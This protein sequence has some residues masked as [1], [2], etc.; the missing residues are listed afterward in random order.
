[1]TSPP[2]LRALFP[3][4]T[5]DERP[6]LLHRRRGAR[7]LAASGA[8]GS[9]ACSRRGVCV[10]PLSRPCWAATLLLMIGGLLAACGVAAR[11]RVAGQ[12]AAPPQE[13]TNT[14]SRG[15]RYYG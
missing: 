15:V 5:A 14:Q 6:R 7:L 12:D 9:L 10:G 4:I 3:V 1:M 8:A 11:R 2:M 13:S